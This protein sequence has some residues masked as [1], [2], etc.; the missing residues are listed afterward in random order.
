[1]HRGEE[2]GRKGGGGGGGG[3]RNRVGPVTRWSGAPWSRVTA[4][5]AEPL[6]PSRQ[7]ELYCNMP[8]PPKGGEVGGGSLSNTMLA[9]V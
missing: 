3:G 6:A 5:M 7:G 1:M 9:D 2:E 4:V 8:C